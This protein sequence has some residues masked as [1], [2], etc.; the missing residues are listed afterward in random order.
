VFEW[1]GRELE[2]MRERAKQQ[3]LRDRLRRTTVQTHLLHPAIVAA[4]SVPP[5]DVV[6]EVTRALRSICRTGE[7]LVD[8]DRLQFAIPLRPAGL[9]ALR[10]RI[11]PSAVGSNV[12][13]TLRASGA[14]WFMLA[15][16]LAGASMI[17]RSAVGATVA[18]VIVAAA[19]VRVRAFRLLRRLALAIPE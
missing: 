10:A 7:P 16:A 17:G 19:V 8:G 1:I 4:T 6:P 15:G 9:I 18:I 11:V 3:S 13:L 5:G 14:V 12:Y 2:A